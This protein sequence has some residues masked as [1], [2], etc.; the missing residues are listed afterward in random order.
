[1]FARVITARTG[2]EGF[3][4]LTRLAQEQ[5]PGAREQPGFQ[6][7]YLLT[8]EETGKA[9]IISLWET[10]EQ[11]EAIGQGTAAGIHDEGTQA[12]GIIAPLLETYEV[13]MQA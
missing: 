6:G 10:R 1:M 7:Y 8:D 12:A 9:V 3:G 5:L 4:E 11:M 2:A 13:T